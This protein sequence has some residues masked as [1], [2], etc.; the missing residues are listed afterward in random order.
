MS[1][2]ARVFEGRDGDYYVCSDDLD[3]LDERGPSYES[4]ASAMR[5]A[6]R[7]G[8]TH[9][10]GSGTYRDGVTSLLPEVMV[11]RF[12]RAVEEQ[13]ASAKRG[14]TASSLNGDT[15]TD[16]QDLITNVLLFISSTEGRDEA[17]SR[18]EAAIQHYLETDDD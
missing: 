4:K 8:Y 1:R 14:I 3:H 12:E 13:I 2:T 16:A 10:V 11:G 18:V 6:A 7:D 17:M 5:A 15:M 9:A